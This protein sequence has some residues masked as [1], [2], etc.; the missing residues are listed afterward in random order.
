M[1]QAKAKK[2]RT[3]CMRYFT[4][5][6]KQFNEVHAQDLPLDL[7]TKAFEK[8]QSCY[9]KLEKA[10]EAYALLADEE[11]E[12]D[13]L[14]NAGDSYQSIL[15]KFGVFQKKAANDELRFQRELAE[16]KERAEYDRKKKEKEDAAAEREVKFEEEK[17]EFELVM[18]NFARLNERVQNVME[19]ASDEDK[20][21][22]LEKL[23]SGMDALKEKLVALGT[24]DPSQDLA[25]LQQTFVDS[26]EKPFSAN[27]KWLLSS[28]KNSTLKSLDSSSSSRSS[29]SGPNTKKEAVTLPSFKGD[30][31]SSPS[32]YLTYPVWR[33]RWDSLI[34]EYEE[35][36]HA[37][38][39]LDRLDDSARLKIVGYEE[40]YVGAMKQ[41]A[42]FY[43]DSMK[44]V[45]CVIAEVSAPSVICE[46]DYR[47]LIDYSVVLE[48]SFNRLRS[49]DLVHELS[50]C[51]SM[52]LML[53]KLPTS[54]AE[55]WAEHI[56]AQSS[57]VKAKPFPELI[58][59]L[60]S[61]KEIWERVASVEASREKGS[62]SM[63]H[64]VSG[65]PPSGGAPPQN[66]SGEM[67]CFGCG[68]SG[69]KRYACPAQR[70]SKGD[71]DKKKNKA[72]PKFKKFWCAF[73]KADATKKGC[74]TISCQ[75]LRQA[76]AAT[77]IRLLKENKDCIHCCGDHDSVNCNRKTRICGGGNVDRGCSQ[78][79]AGHELFCVSAKVFA[80][81]QV[82]S[83]SSD[84]PVVLL[85]TTVPSPQKKECASVFWDLGSTS[86]FV[87]NAFAEKMKFQGRQERL[88][89][90][91]LNGVVT[92]YEVTTY[93]CC[94]MDQNN[95]VHHF[96][97]YGLEC[98][99][100]ALSTID[101]GTIEKLFP[102]EKDV[103]SL[104][105]GPTVDYLIGMGH[106]SWHPKRTDRS[107][108]GGDIWI[109]RGLFGSC[110]GGRHPDIVEKTRRSDQY[111]TVNYVYH[112]EVKVIE[113]VP[114]TLEYCPKRTTSYTHKAGFC[115]SS[116]V[117]KPLC[118]SSPSVE[119]V[120]EVVSSDAMGPMVDVSVDVATHCHAAKTSLIPTEEQFMRSEALG[121]TVSPQCGGCR[122]GK[123]PID[124]SKYNIQEQQDLQEIKRNLKYNAE[125]Q[126]WYTVYP[127]RC[128]R[129][130]L[131]KNDRAAYQ[132]LLSLKRRLS[133]DDDLAKEFCHQ[134]EN[135]LERGVAIVLSDEEVQSWSGDYH[136][137]PLVGVKGKKSLRVCHDASRRQGGHPAM[138]DC[139]RKG[140]DRFLNNLLAVQI[141]FRN[142]RVGFTA[143][144]AKFHNQI[145]LEEPDVHMQ[146][147]YWRNMKTS[148]KPS[149]YAVRV[150]NFG[151]VSANCIATVALHE[152][153][154]VFKDVYP[155]EAEQSMT[156]S[157]LLI[158]L[159]PGGW[160]M[161]R[162]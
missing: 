123:C 63:S 86:N 1:D 75:E 101:A 67:K 30:L 73:H 42:M 39:L 13:Y 126:R 53:G 57:D 38:F 147:F 159:Y 122:C 3:N 120:E 56:V 96:E 19:E 139:L 62:A 112:A 40:D 72:N 141:C 68:K 134:I 107:E 82:Y 116:L 27:R 71:K 102:D 143:D 61:Q 87:R 142:G 104:L 84:A 148:E 133:K 79:H 152:S 74:D 66:S 28:L 155:V 92:D 41:L 48:Q 15:V 140:P 131:P 59:W 94:I 90:T 7:V 34:T 130:T 24:I 158:K 105:R 49:M 5:S 32:P 17:V 69:H 80:V 88:C 58:V 125:E 36:Y 128:P 26:V 154:D 100:G 118:S 77:R 137:L 135:M 150:N 145:Y 110:V 64:F 8:L 14:E 43:G 114:H 25:E 78:K 156:S 21:R 115:E 103:Q 18:G 160:G 16:S 35:K 111:F 83:G 108:K 50:N 85:I 144:I 51:S 124:G 44:V 106:P 89:V 9:N 31:K 81:H 162:T 54:V 23:Q 2:V 76:D 33:K 70:N 46:G 65:F 117:G 6:E 10:Q 93:K 95:D 136:Y 109:Y 132:S 11:E 99:T 127:W 113:E 47:A 129:S 37:N 52:A 20:R 153:A 4:R 157:W 91:T 12:E 98:V 146:R 22:E 55:K 97:A 45:S 149:V 121:T 60:V 138:N 29:S 161:G 119:E 151:V